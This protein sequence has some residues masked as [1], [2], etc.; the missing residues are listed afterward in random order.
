MTARRN[1]IGAWVLAAALAL[2]A[3]PAAA[4]VLTGE[5]QSDGA[6]GIFTPPSMSSPVI[7]RFYVADGTQVKKG[8]R[9]LSIDAGQA[10]SQ[11]RKLRDQIEQAGA[12]TDKEVADLQLKEVDAELALVEA[13][14]ARDTAAV[15][16]ALPR[17]LVSGLDY[18]RYQGTFESATRDARLK[19]T[20]LAAARE[21]VA[22]RQHD[23][24]LETQKA[25]LQ[26]GFNQAQVDAAT[27]VAERDGVVIHLFQPD[28]GIGDGGRYE[29]GST[30]FPGNKVGEVVAPGRR[31]V[32]A[33][34]LEP[35]RTGLKVGQAVR[36]AFDA[37][38]DARVGGRIRAIAGA[39]EAK[40][41]WGEGRYY[42]IDIDL[43]KAAAAL[44]LL[45]GMS[46][47]VQT[48]PQASM[49]P[50]TAATA[51]P[52]KATG[53]V[54]AQQSLAVMPPQVEGLWQMNVTQ[55]AGDGA[56]VGK[57]EPLV[58]FAAGDLAQKLPSTRSELAEKQR[59]Q[60]KLRLELADRARDAALKVAQARADADKARRK[61]QQPKEY[62]AG[63]EYKKLII[64]RHKAEQVLA[65]TERRARV[66]AQARV[67]EQ[68]LA[69]ADVAQLKREADD[70]Q[71]SLASLTVP[72]PRAGLFLHHT[73]WSGDKID[74][75]SQ[76]WRGMSVGEM[77]DMATLAV[78][79]S[80]PER[81]LQQVH[82][83]Q[84]VRVVLAGGASRAIGGRIEGIGDSVH[85]KSRVEP[86][87]VVDLNIH[88]DPTN[89]AL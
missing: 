21:A 3:V 56:K 18:D 51:G 52:L 22:R 24:A 50:A 55:M 82:V 63:V 5:V 4:V 42:A 8:D 33:F 36:L 84:R 71:A 58:V 45:P 26:L 73:S 47:R 10:A 29:E 78:R 61:A 64:D 48:D 7:L 12:K 69:D 62:V 6:Q 35:D 44:P 86:V 54:Y 70:M 39:S 80:L 40:P 87:P 72:A 37:L 30:S 43:D 77:P 1:G 19:A 11:L 67:A 23:G 83:G 49:P 46:V 15:D 65:L 31:S 68:R 85:S 88:L 34:A 75:G 13:E 89:V 81:D 74:V 59:T 20:E 41:E 76:I 60:E 79:A 28:N 25:Q 2:V 57:G 38:P 53:E 32:R 17:S 14:A 27:V 9:V 16:A 66:D